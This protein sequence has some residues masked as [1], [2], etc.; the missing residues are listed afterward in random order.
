MPPHP[1]PS[2]LQDAHVL[3]SDY[4]NLHGRRDKADVIKVTYLE[5]RRF[6]WQHYEVYNYF[7]ETNFSREEIGTQ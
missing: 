4:V 3:F 5:V 7:Y 2:I 1:P 6:L